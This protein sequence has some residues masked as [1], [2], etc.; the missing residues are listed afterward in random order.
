MKFLKGLALAVLGFLLFLSL[1]VFGLVLTLNQ[2]I[3][4]PGFVASQVD[5]LDIPSL[6]E[7]I[8]SEEIP[9]EAEEFMDEIMTEVANDTVADLEPWIKQQVSAS[10]YSFYD[11]LEGRSESLSL[12]IS[13]EPVKESFRDN[14]WKAV[15]ES[16]PPELAG[17]PPAEIEQA[18]NEFWSEFSE[19]I[20]STFEFD[21]ALLGPEVMAQLE[22]ARQI[23]GYI[24]LTYN[25]LIGLILLLILGIVLI[26]REVKG[27]TRKIGITFLSCGIPWF[28]G[29][30][31]AKHFA[32]TQLTQLEM[33]VYLQTWMP[34]FLNDLL[35]PLV[36]F[37]IGLLIAGVAL[38]V[39][40]FV[41]KRRQTEF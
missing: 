41:Y 26:N 31:I 22:Q 29:I 23:V 5:K 8:L 1:S 16:P 11:Y 2:T 20:P 36:M 15:S 7:D 12:A 14:L 3:L 9:P 19:Q 4:N 21:E 25:V 37:S 34:Q 30:F 24:H 32:G 33:P 10:I 17:L 28:V 39:V 27:A 35:A 6:A 13:L 38:L 40:S 18:L